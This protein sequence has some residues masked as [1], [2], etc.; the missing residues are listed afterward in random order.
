MD[1]DE[2]LAEIADKIDG[3]VAQGEAHAQSLSG[4][5]ADMMFYPQTAVNATL[6]LVAAALRSSTQGSCDPLNR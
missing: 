6:K 3:V 5:A 2:L 4:H 1:K